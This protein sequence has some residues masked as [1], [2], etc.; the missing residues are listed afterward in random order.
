MST[1]FTRIL[2]RELPGRFVW[3][4]EVCAAFL[5]I[6]PIRRGHTLVVPRREID[7]WLDA[8][9]EVASHLMNVA[10][11]VGRSINTAYSPTR[12]GLMIAGLEVPHLHIHVLPIDG[13][14]DLDFSN[15]D[16]STTSEQLDEDQRRILAALDRDGLG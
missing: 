15:A 11:T 5:T 2:N 12:V 1:I 7:H 3:E 14:G 13:L 10:Q 9:T 8:P 6:A 16:A 4:D